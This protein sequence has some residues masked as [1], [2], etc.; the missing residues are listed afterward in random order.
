M[1]ARWEEALENA[2]DSVHRNGSRVG[3]AC[4]AVAL[5]RAGRLEEA[6]RAWQELEDRTPGIS[7]AG[8][9]TLLRGIAID[10][11]TADAAAQLSKQSRWSTGEVKT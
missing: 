6:G 7:A 5:A 10:A 8:L 2:G 11:A 9:G 4:Y 1:L 3:W